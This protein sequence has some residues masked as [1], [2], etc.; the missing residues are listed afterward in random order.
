[1]LKASLGKHI[2]LIP[3]MFYDNLSYIQPWEFV[4]FNNTT[5]IKDLSPVI[6]LK[7]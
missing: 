3:N 7:N 4:D 1:M 6:L 5:Y 2:W